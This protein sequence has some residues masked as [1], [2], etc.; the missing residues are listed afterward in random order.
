[1]IIGITGYIGAGK[2]TAATFCKELGYSIVDCDSIGHEILEKDTEIQHKLIG[3][4]GNKIIGRDLKIN[5]EILAELIFNN[6]ENI[7]ELNK[8]IHPKLKAIV[9]Q[10][11][12]KAAQEN[13]KVIVEAAILKEL[14]LDTKVDKI[15]II[16]SEISI[17]YERLKKR[18]SQK[19]V[20]NIMNKQLL[21]KKY[22][23]LILNNESIEELKRRVVEIVNKLSKFS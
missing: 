11:L 17:I 6:Q 1:M 22:D 19:Q 10:L 5:R 20:V 14:E 13:K 3:R 4:Y 18:Y 7:D 23:Y 2:T 16:K 12:D 9:Y 8:I 15:I 21:P